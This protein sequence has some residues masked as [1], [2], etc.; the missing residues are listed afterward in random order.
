[1]IIDLI[2]KAYIKDNK[3]FPSTTGL[4]FVSTTSG[5]VDLDASTPGIYTV[6]NTIPPF[7][8]CKQVTST[9][10]ML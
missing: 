1:M 10:F 7:G 5:E 8:G 9:H 6:T 4:V 3:F 2:G